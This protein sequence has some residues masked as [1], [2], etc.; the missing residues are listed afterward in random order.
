MGAAISAVSLQLFGLDGA[1]YCEVGAVTV[2]HGP[3]G[4]FHQA[5]RGTIYITVGPGL[6]EYLG[7]A[8]WVVAESLRTQ[9]AVRW[10]KILAWP[11]AR[12]VLTAD[13]V[14]WIAAL[15]QFRKGPDS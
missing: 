11:S 1:G 14:R 12:P 3:A 13:S 9:S 4:P 7:S 5:L 15:P 2:Q 10:R 6:P 8:G